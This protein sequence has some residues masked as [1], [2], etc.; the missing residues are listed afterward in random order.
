METE[1][2]TEQEIVALRNR[3]NQIL[4]MRILLIPLLIIP[5]GIITLF[6]GK[7]DVVEIISIIEVAVGGIFLLEIIIILWLS[8]QM[9]RLIFSD[10]PVLRVN[11]EGIIFF[12]RHKFFELKPT[13]IPWSEIAALSCFYSHSLCL[14]VRLKNPEHWWSLYGNGRKR[15]FYVNSRFFGSHFVFSQKF[16]TTPLLPLFQQIQENYAYE[17]QVNEVEIVPFASRFTEASRV[18]EASQENQAG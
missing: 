4:S 5:I 1:Q 3:K 12:D 8:R 7:S 6:L 14:A 16:I 13:L 2:G 18:L 9:L 17:I 11:Q 15:K 10:A